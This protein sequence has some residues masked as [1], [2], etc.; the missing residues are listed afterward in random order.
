MNK[1]IQTPLGILKVH[2]DVP[3]RTKVS[4]DLCNPV[5]ELP[6]GMS[7]DAVV[8][9]MVKLHS[10]EV[11]KNIKCKCIWD[12]PPSEPSPESGEGLDSQSWE[13]TE[14][15]VSIGTEDVDY[16]SSRLSK[17]QFNENECPIEYSENGFSIIFNEIPE[18]YETSLHFAVAWKS[19]PDP[20]DVSTWY[21][22]DIPHEKIKIG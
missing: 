7:V 3:E 15:R 6:Q 22:V 21:A 18:S 9:C 17:I 20:S 10:S 16:L 13:T 14:C 8:V 11:L 12:N 5:I 1:I 4:I 2:V 19:L